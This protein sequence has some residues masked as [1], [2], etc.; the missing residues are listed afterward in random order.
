MKKNL[1]SLEEYHLSWMQGIFEEALKLKRS[2]G[3]LRRDL[4]GRTLGLLFSKPSTRTRVSFEVAM[5]ELG[6]H[7]SFLKGSEIGMGAREEVRDVARTLSRYLS[8]LVVRSHSQKDL[9]EFGRFSTVPVI[10]GLSELFHPCQALTDLF[11]IWERKKTFRGL[12]LAYIG[13]GNNVLHSLL[14]GASRVGLNVRVASP[15]GYGPS[16]RIL[17]LT[18]KV[19]K[20]S[21]AL[22]E[23]GHDPDEAVK[24]AHVVYTD[25]WTSM[26][27][28]KERTKRLRAFQRFQVNSK[29][30]KKAHPKAWV[31]HC[32]PAHRGEEITGSVI[33][34]KHSIVFDQAENRL[35]VQK[36]I[37]LSLLKS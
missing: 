4:S 16:G 32:L 2:R 30:L 11:T 27:Q 6:G 3:K 31:M 36:A 7:T 20:R 33:E 22:L 28:E 37:L 25:V 34:S 13:D 19:F 14:F 1:L 35:H 12:T 17:S 23:V 15:K 21:K 26:G 10:N 24:G 29:L 9:E 8:A 5:Y 18:K